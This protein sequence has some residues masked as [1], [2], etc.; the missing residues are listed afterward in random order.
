VCVIISKA[1]EEDDGRIN[2]VINPK[3]LHSRKQPEERKGKSIRLS[4]RVE[5][6]QISS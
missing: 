6:D 3:K 1:P 2:L 5:D 4:R